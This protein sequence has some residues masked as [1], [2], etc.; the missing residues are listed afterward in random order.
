MSQSNSSLATYWVLH[1]VLGVLLLV[2]KF[3]SVA[4]S[5]FIIS[6]IFLNLG[7]SR[8]QYSAYSIFNKGCQYLLGDARP[9]AVDRQLRGGGGDTHAEEV[10]PT[11]TAPSNFPSKFINRPC[12]CGSG[13]KAKRC[14]ASSRKQTNSK[15]GQNR[16]PLQDEYNYDGFEIVG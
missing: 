7:N 3:D 5:I 1:G 6:V 10:T 12:P 2:S 16:V 4:V 9:D 8:G 15:P 14:C 11:Q 13:L